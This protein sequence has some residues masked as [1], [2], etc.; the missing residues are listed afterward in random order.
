MAKP[1]I[2]DMMR[3]MRIRGEG[4]DPFEQ[5]YKDAKEYD[6]AV[7]RGDKER[8]AKF[9]FSVGPVVSGHYL[10]SLHC[11]GDV[12]LFQLYMASLHV[13]IHSAPTVQTLVWTLQPGNGRFVSVPCMEIH[14]DSTKYVTN[15]IAGTML[16]VQVALDVSSVRCSAS[17]HDTRE[18]AMLVASCKAVI[19][20]SKQVSKLF[21]SLCH[22]ALS[23]GV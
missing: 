10:D 12:L 4:Q 7:K 20:C 6:R 14:K 1:D 5:I 23:H 11:D 17:A 16:Y 3:R 13:N 19:Y 18:C 15:A 8:L 22:R 2:A 21:F 9:D